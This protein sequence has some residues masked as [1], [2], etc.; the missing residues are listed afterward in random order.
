MTTPDP[1][2]Q[3]G[4]TILQHLA[5]KGFNGE[6]LVCGQTTFGVGPEH[7]IAAA[8]S[9]DPVEG[10]ALVPI[11]CANCGYVMFFSARLLPDEG[12]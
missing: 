6:C 1:E 8:P 2:V 9:P 10:T 12:Q 3:R 7:A 4:Q 11:A 5:S